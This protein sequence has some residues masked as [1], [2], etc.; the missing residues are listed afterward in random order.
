MEIIVVEK[1]KSH[2]EMTE[3]PNDYLFSLFGSW[4]RIY[5]L[6]SSRLDLSDELKWD[7]I[8]VVL[9]IL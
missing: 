2:T 8:C 1:R 3:G 9:H 7:S 6:F 4:A 5:H